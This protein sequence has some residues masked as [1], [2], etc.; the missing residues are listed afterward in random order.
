VIG[1]D[2]PPEEHRAL[3]DQLGFDAAAK[4]VVVPTWRARDVTRE[5]DLVEE[6]ARFRLDDVPFTLPRRR[7]MF[8]SLT[9]EQRLRRRCEDVLA[10][11]GLAE[12]YTP[13]LRPD[14]GD[15]PWTL[16]EPITV[17][18]T[19]LR[20]QLVPSLV[21]A[22]RR[23]ADAGAERIALFEVARVYLPS[24]GDLPDERL[25]VG[26]ITEGGFARA[27][28]MV[29]ALYDALKAVPQFE[30]TESP[31]YHP[32]KTAR[33]GA[34]IVGELHPRVLDGVWGAFEL[35]VAALLA[36]SRDPVIYEDVVTYPPVRHDLAFAV[37]E[38][39]P[40]GELVAAAHEAAGPELHEMRPFDVYRGP[41]VGDGRRSIAFRVTFQSAERTLTELDADRLRA[42]VV[43]AL[44]ER[45]GAELR[46]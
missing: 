15:T 39:V 41:Q 34:G 35:E 25:C 13:S 11:L 36:A 6:V 2:T 24:D 28:G 31:L 46:E 22:A 1:V 29:E 33:T 43:T 20:T 10:G 23:N 18:F 21:E 9:R 37:D 8:G 26:A 38:S 44:R 32:G 40:A 16:P 5:I 7:A 19:A 17:D 12:T 3:L 4:R 42:A 14:D 30:R 27:K 45:F